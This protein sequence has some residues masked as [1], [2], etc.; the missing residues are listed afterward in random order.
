MTLKNTDSHVSADGES[1]NGVT[2]NSARAE[3]S[4]FLITDYEVDT[5][6]PNMKST[7]K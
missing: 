6:L 4:A 5:L 1:C 3:T 2:H 7:E